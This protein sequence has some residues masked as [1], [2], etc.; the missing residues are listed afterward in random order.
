LSQKHYPPSV[1]IDE[2]TEDVKQAYL[3]AIL[4]A[5]VCIAQAGACALAELVRVVARRVC[6]IVEGA[7]TRRAGVDV[8][9]EV[10]AA[11]LRERAT[12]CEDDGEDR[13]EDGGEEGLGVHDE[14]TM[15]V[16]VDG[17]TAAHLLY[18]LATELGN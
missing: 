9:A 13:G 6:A 2:S 17:W 10:R 4:C 12:G 7:R 1:S 3:N 8:A 15:V 18:M 14:D 5:G 11:R 16:V